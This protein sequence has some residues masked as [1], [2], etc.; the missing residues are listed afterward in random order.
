MP[1]AADPGATPSIGTN[2]HLNQRNE[3]GL[4]QYLRYGI[5]YKQDRGN[6]ATVPEGK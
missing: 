6:I 3:I 5:R 1:E 4:E 2:A